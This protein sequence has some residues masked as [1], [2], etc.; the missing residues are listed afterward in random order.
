MG[1]REEFAMLR[2][3][4]NENP[5]VL[6]LRLEGR[7]Y[8]P[9]VAVL[10]ECWSKAVSR[11]G[12]RRVRVDLNG[13]TFV[14]FEGKARLAEMYAQGAELL[15]EDLETKAIVAEICGG[16]AGAGDGN[17]N[18]KASQVNNHNS[19]DKLTGE[20]ADLLRLQDELHAVNE[21][22]VKAAR[23]VTQGVE[24][25]GEQKQQVGAAIRAGL[26]RWESVTQRIAQVLGIEREKNNATKAH[27]NEN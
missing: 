23:P 8:G 22:L 17:G 11:R 13:V 2:I 7:L 27:R 16:R 9:W 6:T 3:T 15:G 19:I 5:Q 1:S 14:D 26:K 18:G 24:L 4:T 10:A 21:E 20:L 25:N 12:G